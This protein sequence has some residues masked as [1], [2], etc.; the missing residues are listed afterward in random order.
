MLATWLLWENNNNLTFIWTCFH[1]AGYDGDDIAIMFAVLFIHVVRCL[2]AAKV[3]LEQAK[4]VYLGCTFTLILLPWSFLWSLSH[5]SSDHTGIHVLRRKTYFLQNN[6][7]VLDKSRRSDYPPDEFWRGESWV[8]RQCFCGILILHL[9]D[10]V[11]TGVRNFYS[12]S[13]MPNATKKPREVF[14]FHSTLSFSL[15]TFTPFCSVFPPTS[16]HFLG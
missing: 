1:A 5:L 15:S 4:V 11:V 14:V 2:H 8:G 10:K 16:D 9:K 13:H 3:R 7:Q 12:D 6:H